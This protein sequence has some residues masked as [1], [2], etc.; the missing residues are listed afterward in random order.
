MGFF[1][2]LKKA[3]GGAEDAGEAVKGPSAVLREAGI[4]PAG[5]EFDI[6]GDGS[7]VV[8]GRV[9]NQAASD[10]IGELLS[11]IPQVKSVVNQLEVGPPPAPEP[12][13]EPETE[14]AP[15]PPTAVEPSAPTPVTPSV[16]ESDA[17]EPATEADAA[18]KTYTVQPGDS[19]WKIAAAEYGNGAKY[20]AIFE[21][22]RDI[23]DNPDLIKPGQVLKIPE[24]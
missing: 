9:Y 5:L 20:T 22:N 16:L 18:L 11:G 23:L 21:A 7:L 15:L 24:A 8:S 2:S 14:H 3:L 17:Q 1:D 6:R 10:R 4:D 13:P 12:E 19:L